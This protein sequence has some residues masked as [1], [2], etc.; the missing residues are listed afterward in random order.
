MILKFFVQYM[1]KCLEKKMETTIEEFI[2][3]ESESELG[4]PCLDD[5]AEY[6]VNCD[7]G[8]F[9]F[10]WCPCPW[11]PPSPRAFAS[12]ICDDACAEV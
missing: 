3:L 2:P 8:T 10:Q 6:G 5:C 9:Y 11:F 4:D 1:V 12:T 7:C